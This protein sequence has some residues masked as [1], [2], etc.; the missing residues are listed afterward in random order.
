M[1]AS[2]AKRFL[3]R[4]MLG[5]SELGFALP[6]IE[7]LIPGFDVAIE[8]DAS[9]AKDALNSSDRLLVASD[10]GR[11][12]VFRG[13]EDHDFHDGRAYSISAYLSIDP[14]QFRPSRRREKWHSDLGSNTTRR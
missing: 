3:L 9:L 5:F 1:A 10:L 7:A 13:E 12:A 4:I 11:R 14:D 8:L 6:L 2:S